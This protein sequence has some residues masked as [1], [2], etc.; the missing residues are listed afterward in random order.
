MGRS[1]HSLIIN[2]A[3][4]NEEHIAEVRARMGEL[5]QLKDEQLDKVFSGKPLRFIKNIDHD[6]AQ[7]YCTA[8]DEI[9]MTCQIEDASDNGEASSFELEP[10]DSKNTMF[11][12]DKEKNLFLSNVQSTTS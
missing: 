12:T 6:T 1:T 2:S 8:I 9:G 3:N 10:L 11:E 5:F 7:R 4:V